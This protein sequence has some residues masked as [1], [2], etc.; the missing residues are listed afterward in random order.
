MTL[1]K[2]IL[3]VVGTTLI[4][5]ILVL[6]FTMSR[7]ALNSFAQL[8]R[9]DVHRNLGRVQEA[10]NNASKHSRARLVVVKINK[11]DPNTLHLSITDD[12]VG[13]SEKS[14]HEAP[15]GNGLGMK[16]MRER[17]ESLG[18]TMRVDSSPGAGTTVDVLIPLKE[19]PV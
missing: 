12:G 9:D 15:Q 3:V 2:K 18:G 17:A 1:R 11:E 5:L 10:L 7:I 13:F 14:L 8:E 6:Y 16:T 19:T 4:A